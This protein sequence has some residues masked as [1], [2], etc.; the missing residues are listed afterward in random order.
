LCN[1]KK[2]EKLQEQLETHQNNAQASEFFF[3]LFIFLIYFLLQIEQ[4]TQ[5]QLNVISEVLNLTKK[6][7]QV[8]RRDC[9]PASNCYYPK[10]SQQ[11]T[12]A[13]RFR[14]ITVYHN[15]LTDPINNLHS[16]FIWSQMVAKK[17]CNECISCLHHEIQE[18]KKKM[19][20]FWS[21]ESITVVVITTIQFL[22]HTVYI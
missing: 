12:C 6:D 5:S 7:G 13:Y 17:G 15:I 20:V 3:F 11:P 10:F 22:H 8:F 18:K 1:R 14:A 2:K 4:I 16:S 19:K 9:D 21:L